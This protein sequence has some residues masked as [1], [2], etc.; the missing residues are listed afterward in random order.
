[1]LWSNDEIKGKVLHKLLRA[2]KF[3]H[4]HTAVENMQKGFPKDLIGRVKENIVELV[5]EG[6]LKIKLTN[7]GSQVS[8][9]VDKTED[10][11]KY[12]DVFLR[13]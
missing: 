9:N 12:V 6:L 8:I 10:V 13:K 11:M 7:Y 1:M 3:E 5:K 2:G 4:S